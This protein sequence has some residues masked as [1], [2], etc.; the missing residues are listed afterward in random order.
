MHYHVSQSFCGGEAR[1]LVGGGGASS[2]V[3]TCIVLYL[4]FEKHAPWHIKGDIQYVFMKMRYCGSCRV[5]GSE[6]NL[7]A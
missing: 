1:L 4:S 3:A 7:I 6:T 2:S 5:L